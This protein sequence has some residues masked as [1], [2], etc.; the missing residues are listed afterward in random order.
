MKDKIIGAALECFG[1]YGPQ[2]TSMADI[3]EATGISRK[4]LYRHFEDRT[5]LIEQVLLHRMRVFATKIEEQVATYT[6]FKKAL[7]SGS[8]AAVATARE[9]TLF[10]EIVQRATSHRVEQ[11]L[12]GFGR[13]DEIIRATHRIWD[14]AIAMG[15]EQGAVRQDLSNERI[16]ELIIGIQALLLMRDD[17]GPTEQRTF[18]QDVLVPAITGRVS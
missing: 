17:Y 10:N 9:D 15:R 11:F 16:V 1:Q 13:R 18:L 2:R 4:T 14:S 5:A 12:F 3:A 6:D 7:V 8:I